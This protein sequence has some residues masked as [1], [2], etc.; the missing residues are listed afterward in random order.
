MSYKKQH[1]G[2]QYHS[3]PR[4]HLA[5]TMGKDK[6]LTKVWVPDDPNEKAHPR[7]KGH[8]AL[9]SDPKGQL[10]PVWVID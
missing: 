10:Y 9:N 3:R 4:G 1:T 2:Q 6:R 5:I 8:W 7:G